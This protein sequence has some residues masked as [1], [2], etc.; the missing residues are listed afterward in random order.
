MPEN[1]NY[2]QVELEQLFAERTDMWDFLQQGSLDGVWY[3]DLENPENEWLS[4]EFWHLLGYDPAEREHKPEEWQ[5]IIN[6]D[7]LKVALENFH[8]HVENPDHPYDQI[9]RYTHRDGSTVWVRCRGL[10]IRDS[11]GKAIRMLGA[12]NDLT[13]VMRSESVA[14][15]ALAAAETANEELR[16]F[17]YSV[18]HDMKAP[19][20]TLHMILNELLETESGRLTDDQLDLIE[21]ARNS[22]RSMR[23]LIEDLLEFT[24][25]IGEDI[26]L[27][28]LN[29][30]EPIEQAINDLKSEI[31][32]TGA[33]ID[34]QELPPVL[35]HVGQLRALFQNLLNNSIKYRKP[36]IAP[37]IEIFSQP[38]S[39]N[40]KVDICI[41]DNGIGIKPE[42]FGRIFEMFKR[43]HRSDEI[44]GV[45]LGLTLCRR[46]AVGH[47]GAISVESTPGEGAT[48]IVTLSKDMS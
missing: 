48:F 41:R 45:G 13:A 4:E 8:K 16:A 3:W 28:H 34:V 23:T 25:T 2:L 42:Y 7:D 37:K 43:L 10:A 15:A 21:I 47:G 17:A 5:D 29:L 36:G 32:R 33:Q 35:G 11:N 46:I 26:V 20:N 22:V 9:V 38:G 24:R 40:D 27:E 30:K 39:D 31:Q 14:Q 19:S 1:K 44:P 12:H 6:A 18:S